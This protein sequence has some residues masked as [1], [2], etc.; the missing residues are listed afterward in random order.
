MSNLR[1]HFL[2]ARVDYGRTALLLVFAA[3]GILLMGEVFAIDGNYS[4][5]YASQWDS[6]D[7]AATISDETLLGIILL[8][9]NTV[10]TAYYAVRYRIRHSRKVI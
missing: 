6:R 10:V 5:P 2:R 3:A 9:L 7:S 4:S 8:M 1:R